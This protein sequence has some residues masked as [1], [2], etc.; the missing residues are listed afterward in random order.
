MKVLN[1]NDITPTKI[2]ALIQAPSGNGKTY[3][4]RTLPPKTIIVNLDEGLL[5]LRGS[6]IDYV[7]IDRNNP[8][9]SMQSILMEI[10]KSDY[11]NVYIDSLTEVGEDLLNEAKKD[12]PDARQTMPRYGKQREMFISF[13]KFTRSMDKNVFYTVLE[14]ADKNDIG[15]KVYLPN[16]VG[17]IKEEI[18][19]YFDFVFALRISESDEGIKRRI[20]QTDSRDGYECKDRSGKLNEFEVADLGLVI[21]KVFNKDEKDV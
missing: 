6:G 20:L 16:L 18:G 8:Y 11:D 13:I 1:T 21:N 7:N 3:L 5:S 4:A 12:F 10:S 14:K 15:Q 9:K 2:N 19:S 17:S